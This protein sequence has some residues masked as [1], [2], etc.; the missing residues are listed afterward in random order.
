MTKQR[1]QSLDPKGIPEKSDHPTPHQPD[2]PQKPKQDAQTWLLLAFKQRLELQT[3]TL[4]TQPNRDTSEISY[5]FHG[6]LAIKSPQ[7]PGVFYHQGKTPPRNPA[8]GIEQD[9]PT[10]FST[11]TCYIPSADT[12]SRGT[13]CLGH[14]S[15][16]SCLEKTLRVKGGSAPPAARGTDPALLH[17]RLSARCQPGWEPARA[18]NKATNSR[19]K[20]HTL[21]SG[22]NPTSQS[23]HAQMLPRSL[24]GHLRAFQLQQIPKMPIRNG[25][26]GT[27]KP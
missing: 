3:R 10:R 1:Q 16:G 17:P 27:A 11:L 12:S 25:P 24:Q 14:N 4:G 21:L 23:K 6:G 8:E 13:C 9:N 19:R 22:Q 2:Q 7:I 18:K 26:I 5:Q 20:E 15:E